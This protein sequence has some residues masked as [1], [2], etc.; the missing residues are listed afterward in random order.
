MQKDKIRRLEFAMFSF[1]TG[2]NGSFALGDNDF[3]LFFCYR[4][5]VPT[6]TMQPIFVIRCWTHFWMQKFKIRTQMA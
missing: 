5:I 2:G 6:V 3:I 1:A 4:Q